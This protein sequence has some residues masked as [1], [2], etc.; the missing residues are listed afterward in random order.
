MFS[1]TTQILATSVQTALTVQ[2]SCF[3]LTR[4]MM[5]RF[6]GRFIL[7]M[8]TMPRQRTNMRASQ[9]AF[10][11]LVL[12]VQALAIDR[13]GFEMRIP[14][15]TK[16]SDLVCT[17]RVDSVS[18]TDKTIKHIF[19][20]EKDKLPTFV[21]FKGGALSLT[22]WQA[23]VRVLN[24]FHGEAPSELEVVIPRRPIPKKSGM[25]FPDVRDRLP[26][27]EKGEYY[28]VFLKKHK[29]KYLLTTMLGSAIS[30]A[31][32]SAQENGSI[33]DTLKS[34]IQSTNDFSHLRNL[35]LCLRELMSADE[36]ALFLGEVLRQTDDASIETACLEVLV[37]PGSN[38]LILRAI[39]LIRKA[40]KAHE[41][42]T[43]N[44][45]IRSDFTRIARALSSTVSMALRSWSETSPS[46]DREIKKVLLKER[47]GSFLFQAVVRAVVNAQ[48][49]KNKPV[50]VECLLKRWEEI[51]KKD[52]QTL[53]WLRLAL[54]RLD[55]AD[56]LGVD[57]VEFSKDPKKYM[58]PVIEKYRKQEAWHEK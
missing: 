40:E 5:T 3:C 56:R 21:R 2:N 24:V 46:V 9:F 17:I 22:I 39:S 6:A 18:S 19:N 13:S 10:L 34:E 38:E 32:E 43:G 26:N 57:I 11:F 28:L 16:A 48:S 58:L 45:R 30:L 42:N 49:D 36:L 20:Y 41:R 15:L 31:G 35:I 8:L 55:R 54:A 23:E 50:V 12:S 4:T 25:Y 52:V 14:D 47:V 44:A 1:L 7:A 51:L 37:S 33:I 29:Q 27:L 53:F